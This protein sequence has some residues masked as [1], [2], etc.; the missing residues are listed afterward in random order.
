MK[1]LLYG[2]LT[3]ADVVGTIVP[4]G[5]LESRREGE[6]AT[7][8]LHRAEQEEI[9]LKE[10]TTPVIRSQEYVPLVVKAEN[11][12]N[13]GQS[14][15]KIYVEGQ[16]VDEQPILEAI[17]NV[18]EKSLFEQIFTLLPLGGLAAFA[19]LL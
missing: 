15:G 1:V 9:E 19:F 13:P 16:L 6:T 7:E 5:F 3:A 4:A 2:D 18:E 10:V 11:V 14:T 12:I 8:A 17:S